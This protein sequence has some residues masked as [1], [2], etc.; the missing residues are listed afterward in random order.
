MT[1]AY[2]VEYRNGDVEILD[3]YDRPGA[4]DFV[5]AEPL[6]MLFSVDHGLRCGDETVGV[7]IASLAAEIM[8]PLLAWLGLD[9]YRVD[10]WQAMADEIGDPSWTGGWWDGDAAILYELRDEMESAAADVGLLVESSSDAGM[11]WCYRRA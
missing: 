10:T 6:K 4:V 3:G 9:T 5:S 1:E 8:F 11:T 7:I 2:L